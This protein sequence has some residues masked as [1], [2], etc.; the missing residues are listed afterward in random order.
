MSEV[1]PVNFIIPPYILERLATSMDERVRRLALENIEAMAAARAMR[2]TLAHAPMLLLSA[3][4]HGARHRLVYDARHGTSLPG[5]LARSEGDPAAG[6]AAVDEAYRHCGS[7]YDFFHRVLGRN[8]LDDRGLT[9]K[10]SVHFGSRYGNAFWNGAQMVFGDGDGVVFRR[11]TRSLDVV[12]HELTHGV[13][14][15]TANL[16]YQDEPGALNE[17]FADVFG[18]LVKQ[19]RRRQAAREA[20]WLIGDDILVRRPTRRAIRDMAAPGTAYRNDPELGDDPQPAHVRRKYTG[21]ADN[22]GVH[23]NSGIPNRAFHL[24][25]TAMGGRAWEKAGRI[26]YETLLALHRTSSFS[27]CARTTWQKACAL[28]GSSGPEQQAVRD[29]W[30]EVGIRVSALRGRRGRRSP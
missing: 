5:A 1:G 29:A 14:A 4:P 20:N 23:V 19:W 7:T 2:A 26:W 28:Y 18:I 9:L 30:A 8:S 12:G 11:F 15:F 21:P 17:H 24:A 3:S 6:D 27:D 22:G 10:S 13:V 25:A 16:E